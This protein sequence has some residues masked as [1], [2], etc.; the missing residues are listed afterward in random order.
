MMIEYSL[1]DHLLRLVALLSAGSS[2]GLTGTWNL[3]V[4][5]GNCY[6]K[7]CHHTSSVKVCNNKRIIPNHSFC[8][9]W[10]MINNISK[11]VLNI[12]TFNTRLWCISL[13]SPPL[14]PGFF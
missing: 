7:P 3:A 12:I 2:L 5:V 11:Y 13:Y 9:I 10:Y 14:P 8:N 6:P 1:A 4:K